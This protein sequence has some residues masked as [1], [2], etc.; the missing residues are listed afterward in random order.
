MTT[1]IPARG[2]YKPAEGFT[3]AEMN[4]I[5]QLADEALALVE[6]GEFDRVPDAVYS[7]GKDGEWDSGVED[8]A[9]IWAEQ[10]RNGQIKELGA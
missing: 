3:D 1:W 6:A 2:W 8:A 9:I 5:G 4:R 7:L 10:S